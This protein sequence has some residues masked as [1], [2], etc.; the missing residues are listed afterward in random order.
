MRSLNGGTFPLAV[1]A[2]VLGLAGCSGKGTTTGKRVTFETRAA[3][4]AEVRGAFL[5]SFGWNVKLDKAAVAVGSLYY[6]DGEPAFVEHPV[7]RRGPLERFASFFGEGVAHAHPG[8][9]QAGGALGQM[10]EPGSVD[11]FATSTKLGA[12]DGVTGTYRSA[13]FTF[14]KKDTGVAASELSGHAAFAEGTATKDGDGGVA[15][16]HFRVWADFPDLAKSVKEGEVDGCEFQETDVENDG[17]VTVTVKPSVWF[18]LVDFSK[19]EPGTAEAPTEIPHG[20]IAQIGFALGLVQLSAYHFGY[21][22]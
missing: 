15:T 18:D 14:A 19:V 11:L 4:D 13:R 2:V 3:A 8:H 22:G 21:S 7:P 9:Y 20:D 12:G 5:T 6:F 17:T 1:V 16:I 10:L